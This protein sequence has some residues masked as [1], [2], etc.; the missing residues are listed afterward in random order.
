MSRCAPHSLP[1]P[2]VPDRPYK[3]L[4]LQ[5]GTLS[6]SHPSI[7][8]SFLFLSFGVTGSA[9]KTAKALKKD[10]TKTTLSHSRQ[11]RHRCELARASTITGTPRKQNSFPLGI[12]PRTC[13]DN[14]VAA[15]QLLLPLLLGARQPHQLA[16]PSEREA[17]VGLESNPTVMTKYAR[18]LGVAD[19]WGF[20]DL[21]VRLR[22]ACE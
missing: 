4:L 1:F 18:S 2:C 10:F 22:S 13:R 19:G 7:G 16:M 5:V 15:T 14:P 20:C 17:W 6:S 21:W 8:L 11:A 3:I 12:A 9:A